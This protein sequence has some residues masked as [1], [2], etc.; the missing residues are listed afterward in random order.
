MSDT[1][2]IYV[3]II[4]EHGVEAYRPAPADPVGPLIYRLI[5][6][7]PEDEAWEFQPGELV[8][9]KD[10]VFSGGSRGLVAVAHFGLP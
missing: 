6:P 8:L 9:C 3:A 10:R 4:G 1:A 7:V 5:G 2:T